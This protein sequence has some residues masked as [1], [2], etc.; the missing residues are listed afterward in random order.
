[1]LTN[2]RFINNYKTLMKP[3][4]SNTGIYENVCES[5]RERDKQS[6]PLLRNRLAG[7]QFNA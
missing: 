1:M 4:Y 7:L 6:S 2:K 3:I 5:V